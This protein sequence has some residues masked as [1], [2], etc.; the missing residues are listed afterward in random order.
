MTLWPNFWISI[1]YSHLQVCNWLASQWLV[2]SSTGAVRANV[3]CQ[4]RTLPDTPITAKVS[5]SATGRKSTVCAT[6]NSLRSITQIQSLR[7]PHADR[8]CRMA[9]S[10]PITSQS[11]TVPETTT[12]CRDLARLVARTQRSHQSIPARHLQTTCPPSCTSTTAAH[13]IAH[14]PDTGQVTPLSR[15]PETIHIHGMHLN[16]DSPHSMSWK[17]CLK[18]YK[19]D[20][21]YSQNR[22]SLSKRPREWVNVLINSSLVVGNEYT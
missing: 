20:G 8:P 18:S 7:S 6:I 22:F 5:A 19:K 17:S 21:D 16:P 15:Q 9:T 14:N 1:N 13:G 12:M 2:Q 3:C 11:A 4:S 10:Q